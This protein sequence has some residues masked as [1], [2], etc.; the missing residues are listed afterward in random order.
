MIQS[1]GPASN[2]HLVSSRTYSPKKRAGFRRRDG[3]G[4]TLR[5]QKKLHVLDGVAHR[6]CFDR[7]LPSMARL[8]STPSAVSE[9]SR[10]STSSVHD[11]SVQ[12]K[13]ATMESP[14]RTPPLL[15]CRYRPYRS[16]AHLV[17]GATRAIEQYYLLGI[18]VDDGGGFLWTIDALKMLAR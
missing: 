14:R 18:I 11:Q 8:R 13:S 4:I 10:A 3:R 6:P 9:A 16:S 5:Y 12:R 1:A 7:V 17:I 2:W 15:R